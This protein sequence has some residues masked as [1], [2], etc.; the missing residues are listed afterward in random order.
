LI[1]AFSKLGGLLAFLKI[2]TVLNYMHKR[3][4]DKEINKI[5]AQ[6]KIVPVKD[7]EEED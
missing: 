2:A 4:F 6:S 7:K 5:I 1:A 3:W